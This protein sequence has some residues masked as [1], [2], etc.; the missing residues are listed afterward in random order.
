MTNEELQLDNRTVEQIIDDMDLFDDDLM[1]MVFDGNI[2]AAELLL[3]IILKRDDITVINVVGQREFQNPVV[4]GRNIRLDI[5]AKDSTGKNYNVEVQKKPE[6]AHIRRARFNSS[7][8]DSRMLKEGQEF[9]ELQDSYMVFITQADIFGYGIPI[10]TINRHFE[11]IDDLFDDGSH[12]IY[13]NGGYKGNDAVGKLMH[14]FG[15]RESKD[16]YYSELAKG[17]K[18]FKE[19]EGGRRAMCEAVERYA[20]KKAVE[21]RNIITKI[22]GALAADKDNETIIRELNCTLEQII[23]IRTAMG[24]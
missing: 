3:K 1:S 14:D 6:G 13:V 17:V 18:H 2:P 8:M 10:Y 24:K 4:G 19:E 16:M 11:E 15:C 9:S 23:P 7:M 12:I 21:E 22:V 20:E 5:L